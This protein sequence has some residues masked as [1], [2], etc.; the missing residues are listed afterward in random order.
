MAQPPLSH[1]FAMGQS[2]NN[3]ST[4]ERSWIDPGA[5]FF[6]NKIVIRSGA[7]S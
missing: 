4:D 5:F 2:K 1:V 3:A 7:S 6:N